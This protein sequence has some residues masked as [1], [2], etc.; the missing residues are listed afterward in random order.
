M[1][2]YQEKMN[3]ELL[4]NSRQTVFEQDVRYSSWL[5]IIGQFLVLAIS[6]IFLS[7]FLNDFIK[8]INKL[9]KINLKSVLGLIKPY[10]SNI[11]I[12]ILGS[13]GFY[14]LNNFMIEGSY[15]SLFDALMTKNDIFSFILFIFFVSLGIRTLTV[16]EYKHMNKFTW[17]IFI[18]NP[19]ISFL[20]L[21][22]CYN[23][24]ILSME[25]IYVLINSFI[26][27]LVQLFVYFIIRYKRSSMIVVVIVSLIFGLSNDFL[28]ILRDSPLIPAFLGSLGV[29]ADVAS[30]T[31]IEFNGMAISSFALGI[32]WLMIIRSVN[33]G[34]IEITK[35]R[36]LV[37]LGSFT[38]V[39]AVS[40]IVSANF[41]LNQVTVG[42]NLWRPSRTYYVEGAPYSFYRI[43][44]K[45]LIT[46]PEGYDQAKVEK[47]LDKYYK[48][49]DQ[50]NSISSESK[51]GL[52]NLRETQMTDEERKNE[53]LLASNSNNK[54]TNLTA[55]NNKKQEEKKP[56]IIIIQS[57]SLADYYGQGNL[58]LTKNPLE[59]TRSLKENTIQGFAYMS[60]LG[61]GTVNSEFEVLTSLPLAFFPAG[62]YPFQQYVKNGHTSIGRILKN[63]G[64][65]TWISHPNKPTN[66]SRQEVWPNLGFENT[67]FIDDYQDAKYVHSYVS[68]ESAYNNIIKQFEE[69]KAK[70]KNN[71]LF[72]YLVSMQ[73]HGAY[74]GS[75][76]E[77]DVKI[78]GHEGL[79]PSAEEYI[80]LV[81]LSDKDFK[82]LVNYFSSYDEPT[83]ICIFGDHQ[84]SIYSYFLDIAYG[85][86]NY[87]D[88]QAY[89]TPLTIWANYDI[90][91]QENVNISLNYLAPY[92]FSKAK[93][94]KTSAY[95]N[96]LLDMM[97]DYPIITTRFILDKD[98]ND[99]RND[100][101]FLERDKELNSL[102]YYQ[103][104]DQDANNKYFNY[105]ALGEN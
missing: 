105:P 80:N 28:M 14:V 23:P 61:G 29:A 84:P 60:V 67:S 85:E 16:N 82:K 34:K 64:Y 24:N 98:G 101:T 91:E 19:L 17:F 96:Y 32:M 10:S 5:S 15:L 36:Y 57:E 56:N 104:K 62:A 20:I 50:L 76:K 70:S 63:Q 69:K 38:A 2:T 7:I 92:L 54:D 43:T 66:Y 68:D 3:I 72:A 47:T 8:K 27:I 86:N 90:E 26:L 25:P 13:L 78:I 103:V 88:L 21:E 74:I 97:K 48:G 71:P 53:S 42:V 4:A 22:S 81:D 59:Y 18:I 11:V 41:F 46:A 93:G 45:Q 35:K 44:V 102:I 95:E 94:I 73:N 65:D 83:I 31:V 40:I 87:T 1:I 52:K 37:G 99:V 100:Q 33:P 58:K 6:V 9:D 51:E 30:N 75:Y 55:N 89:K 77:G 49:K 39:L 12:L 79:N